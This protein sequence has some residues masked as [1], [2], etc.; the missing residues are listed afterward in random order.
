MGSIFDKGKCVHL[1]ANF[2]SAL[3]EIL[4][5]FNFAYTNVPHFKDEKNFQDPP[6]KREIYMPE[7]GAYDKS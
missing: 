1:S 5:H 2:N 6:Y 4:D 3:L 7:L